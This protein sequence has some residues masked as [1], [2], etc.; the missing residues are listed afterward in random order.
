[1]TQTPWLAGSRACAA[2]TVSASTASGV[3]PVDEFPRGLSAAQNGRRSRL[4]DSRGYCVS[5]IRGSD[6]QPACF[7]SAACVQGFYSH[8][9]FQCQIAQLLL[10]DLIE[11]QL[12]KLAVHLEELQVTVV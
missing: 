2:G 1:M 12:P 9:M 5:P 6:Q 8:D 10:Q 7:C 11:A 4:L 3:L